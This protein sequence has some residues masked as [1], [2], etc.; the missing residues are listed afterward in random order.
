MKH[1]FTTELQKISGMTDGMIRKD[2]FPDKILPAYLRDAVI[3]YPSRG[4]KRLRPAIL[5]WSCGLVGGRPESA[6]FAAAAV[7][8]YHNWTLVHDDIIDN[9]NLRRG[10]PSAHFIM[11][12]DAKKKFK[13][14]NEEADAFGKNLAMLAGDIQQA[15][16][17]N[18]M[19]KSV[20]AG[21]TPEL[22]IHLSRRLHEHVN[23]NLISGEALDIEMPLLKFERISPVAIEKMLELKTGA[24][25]RYCAES[26][27]LIGL[28]S[29]K[30]ADDMRVRKLGDFALLSGKAF[31]L[32]D[33]WLGIFGDEQKLGK[34]VGSDLSEKKPTLLVYLAWKNLDA[35]GKKKLLGLLGQKS[36]SSKEIAIVQRLIR[37]SGAETEVLRRAGTLANFAKE[38][39]FSFPENK[40]RKLLLNL[41]DYLTAREF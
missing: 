38:L 30:F 10:K 34:P 13:M 28:G 35:K 8:I 21:V 17:S 18:M 11:K 19:L 31:Q 39:L 37:S 27:A 41:A 14:K 36:Y 9:D 33:D 29:A 6:K 15:W 24:L 2:D 1:I 16:A 5:L 3:D 40:Y 4:G 26:G 32:K 25:L 22:T 20:D 7:E 23:R 12:N